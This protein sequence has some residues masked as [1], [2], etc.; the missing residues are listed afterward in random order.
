[1]AASVGVLSHSLIFGVLLEPSAFHVAGSKATVSMSSSELSTYADLR[2]LLERVPREASVTATE[3]ESPLISTRL[4]A[5]S[6]AL[7]D[8]DAEYVLIHRD[9]FVLDARKH[10]HDLFS[11][12]PFG[13]VE[14]RGNAYLF[15][16]GEKTPGT[17]AAEQSLGIAPRASR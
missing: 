17:D 10:L 8:A 5:Y 7:R 15:K 16:R 13:L 11:R 3:F 4:N 9:H 14:Q 1:L 12:H 2:A 6:A